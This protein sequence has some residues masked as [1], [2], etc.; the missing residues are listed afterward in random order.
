M[1][2][3]L[4]SYFLGGKYFFENKFS[5]IL[6]FLGLLYVLGYFKQNFFFHF[7]FLTKSPYLFTISVGQLYTTA[8]HGNTLKP[9]PFAAFPSLHPFFYFAA[10]VLQ[11]ATSL[12]GKTI[13]LHSKLH[14]YFF[15]APSIQWG[16]NIKKGI[17]LQSDLGQKPK[18]G[19]RKFCYISAVLWSIIFLLLIRKLK[20]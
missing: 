15:T 13:T 19:E 17:I 16:E 12:I 10:F 1:K 7:F 4:K 8:E 3:F 11:K 6:S 14:A 20:Y 9:R 18:N 2:V 5:I